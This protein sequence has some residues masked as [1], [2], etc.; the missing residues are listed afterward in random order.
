MQENHVSV[1]LQVPKLTRR[2]LSL[3][4]D[5]KIASILRTLLTVPCHLKDPTYTLVPR[6]K[7]SCL[8]LMIK[9]NLA[10]SYDNVIPRVATHWIIGFQGY[11]NYCRIHPWE[12]PEVFFVRF[13]PTGAHTEQN[14]YKSIIFSPD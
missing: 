6:R 4:S 3:I 8:T 14:L 2:P 11:V 7:G 1:F 9:R 12:R 10:K 13:F 5:T